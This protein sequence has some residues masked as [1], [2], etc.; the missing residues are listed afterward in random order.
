MFFFFTI[1]CYFYDYFLK[2]LVV[3]KEIAAV[4]LSYQTPQKVSELFTDC[5]S[6]IFTIKGL[7]FCPSDLSS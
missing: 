5:V 1:L 2:V 4:V 7:G 6:E 3:L